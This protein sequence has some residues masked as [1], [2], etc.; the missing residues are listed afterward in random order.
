MCVGKS[1]HFGG[2]LFFVD[3][4]YVTSFYNSAHRPLRRMP[5]LWSVSRHLSSV[6]LV[7]LSRYAACGILIAIQQS[8]KLAP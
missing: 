2:T 3:C 8:G 4:D 5:T 6:T 7:R 1:H